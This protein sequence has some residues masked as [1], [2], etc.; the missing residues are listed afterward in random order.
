MLELTDSAQKPCGS[1]I[2]DPAVPLDFL[3]HLAA[4][5]RE[6]QEILPPH[7]RVI[8]VKAVS[9]IIQRPCF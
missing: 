4:L 7:S 1:P 9:D 6:T 5:A 3:S 2:C 8:S